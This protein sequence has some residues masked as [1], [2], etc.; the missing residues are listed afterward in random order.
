MRLKF[1][2]RDRGSFS[3]GLLRFLPVCC[4]DCAECISAVR[5]IKGL[6]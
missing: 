5:T 3:G 4:R 1:I 2:R 6:W